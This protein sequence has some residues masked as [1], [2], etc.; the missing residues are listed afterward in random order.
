MS[1]SGIGTTRWTGTRHGAEEGLTMRRV[2][3]SVGCALVLCVHIGVHLFGHIQ[4]MSQ[5]SSMVYHGEPLLTSNDGYFHLDVADRLVRPDPHRPLTRDSEISLL[6]RITA[7]THELSGIPLRTVAYWASPVLASGVLFALLFIGTSVFARPE[8]GIIAAL[9][10][11]TSP[12]WYLRTRV[13]YF[14]TDSLIPFFL[15]GA[16]ACVAGFVKSQGTKR[17][18]WFGG[19]CLCCISGGLWWPQAWWLIGA[20]SLAGYCATIL[21]PSSRKETQLKAVFLGVGAA[22]L[23]LTVFNL[24]RLVPDFLAAPL[25]SLRAH[26]WLVIAGGEQGGLPRAHV[27]E[28]TPV[29]SLSL[30]KFING[31]YAG[32]AASLAGLFFLALR[33]RQVFLP[34]VPML[35]LGLL[36]VVAARF[37]VFMLPLYAL[38]VGWLCSEFLHFRFMID[39]APKETARWGIVALAALVIV[40]PSGAVTVR[41]PVAPAFD[42][43]QASFAER[44][45]QATEPG[46]ML[47]SSWSNGYFLS[48]FAKRE[49]R[50]HGGTLAPEALYIAEAPLCAANPHLA[51]N[52]I[53]FFTARGFE[54]A[55]RIEQA[56]GLSPTQALNLLWELLASPTGATAALAQRQ[57]SDIDGWLQYL[58]PRANAAVYLDRAMLET[59]PD[60]FSRGTWDFEAGSGAT[61][62][63][64]GG[65]SLGIPLEVMAQ[66]MQVKGKPLPVS[67]IIRIGG[68]GAQAEYIAAS[69]AEGGAL[70]EFLGRGLPRFWLG[71]RFL[72]SLYA[73]LFIDAPRAT[74]GFSLLFSEPQ[75][76]GAWALSECVQQEAVASEPGS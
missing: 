28:L 63:T 39:L 33:Q 8:A 40:V 45:G 17:W 30:I 9:I 23:L 41:L 12:Y 19:C 7:A 35:I 57:A 51:A 72:K 53:R 56:W 60:W 76:A 61:D 67:Q 34:F 68:A 65:E 16:L 13:G 22:L 69:P 32:L 54:G 73:Q 20:M 18:P 48:Y 42:V 70:V 14:D 55:R 38:G 29:A 6:S 47:W 3:V 1:L 5:S 2:L 11:A 43:R 74:P 31:S 71:P 58:F 52:W 49:A 50:V 27:G 26:V 25:S 66:T 10:Q 4:V 24:Q 15:L 75:D 62:Q 44:L 21:V 46:T 36:T 64:F 37:S 59:A